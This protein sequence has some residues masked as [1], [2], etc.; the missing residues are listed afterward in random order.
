MRIRRTNGATR[1]TD[2]ISSEEILWHLSA[3][4]LVGRGLDTSADRALRPGLER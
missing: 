4:G 1:R 2:A 3:S